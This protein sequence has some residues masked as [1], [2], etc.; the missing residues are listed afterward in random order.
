MTQVSQGG[1]G[2]APA[3]PGGAT[4]PQEGERAH[5]TWWGRTY[6]PREIEAAKQQWQE[7]R[8]WDSPMAWADKVL[9]GTMVA[10]IVLAVVSLPL[11]PFLLGSHPVAT[12][13]VTGSSSAIGAGAAFARLGQAELWVVIAAG[14]IG[15]IKFDWLYWWAG[16]RWGGKGVRFFVPT[17][18][19]QRLVPR[20]RSWPA[21]GKFLLVIAA[22]VPGVPSILTFLLAGL[23]GMS[24]PTFLLADA[25][26]AGLMTG[27]VAGLGYG[28]GQQAVDV[29]LLIDRYALWITLA[30]AAV[31]AV[32]ATRAQLARQKKQQA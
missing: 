18:R 5:R 22:S 13:A 30:F 32:Q 23:A 3:R 19:A 9:I 8:P 26:G 4:G 21:W 24:L 6:S 14:I 28:L 31:I 1:E 27:L 17:D 10:A 25:L 12:A 2:A 15:K 7:L 11:R 29:V 20:L 16:R